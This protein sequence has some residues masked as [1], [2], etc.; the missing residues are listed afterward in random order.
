MVKPDCYTQT[1]KIIDAIYQNGFTISKLK[2]SKFSQAQHADEFY[3][4]HRGKPFFSD[5]CNYMASDVV[6][7][8]EL[9][10]E[11]AISTFRDVIGPTDPA[12]AK[13]QAR[14][15]IRAH[16]GTDGMRNAIHGSGH[17]SDFQRESAFFFSKAFAPTAAF[18]NCTCAI[19]KPHIV[20]SGQAGQVIDMILQ[21][22][23]EISSM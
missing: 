10:K 17:A 1:G 21:E 4:E 8:M 13:V 16:F 7:G 9:V 5:L 11:N 2:M 6:T 19:I 3:A 22:G 20:Q 14:N 12:E 18:N 23:F 15:S